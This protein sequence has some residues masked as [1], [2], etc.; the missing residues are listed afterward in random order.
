VTGTARAGAVFAVSFGSFA[1]CSFARVHLQFAVTR[2]NTGN[3]RDSG[4]RP[5]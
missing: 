4:H 5:H 1:K 2:E 3:F